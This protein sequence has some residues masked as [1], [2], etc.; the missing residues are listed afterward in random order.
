MAEQ[1]IMK[2][3]SKLFMFVYSSPL[4]KKNELQQI[5]QFG[6]KNPAH[7]LIHNDVT[8]SAPDNSLKSFLQLLHNKNIRT[9]N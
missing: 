8:I 5:G 3:N 7:K 1:A 4:F 9:I 2:E 6:E